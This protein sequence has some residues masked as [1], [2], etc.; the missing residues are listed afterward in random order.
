MIIVNLKGG[1]GNQTFQYALA[2]VLARRNE[3]QVAC[4]QRFLDERNR[5]RPRG[6][7]P[8]DVGLGDFGIS[9]ESPDRL[10]LIRTLMF[11]PSYAA[12]AA[13]ASVLD[14]LGSCTL[15]ERRRTFEPRVIKHREPTLY[16]D[17][18]WQSEHY[19]DGRHDDI[20]RLFA[21]GGKALHWARE[22][23]VITPEIV[24]DAACV[25]VRRGDFVG[26]RE[27]DC[28]PSNY[29]TQAFQRLQDRV[30]R[31][32]RPYVFSDDHRWCQRHIELPNEPIF[33]ACSPEATNPA[34]TLACMR[35]FRYFVIPNSTFGWW[36]AWLAA[37]EGK[38]VV[39]PRRWSG[40]L[41]V[42]KVDIVPPDW[43]TA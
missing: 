24:G 2:Y 21:T 22:L 5:R 28:L 27:H 41:A 17:G 40:T 42:D 36:G 14:R 8:R 16:L 31:P 13:I 1:L 6:Y 9:V 12:R 11:P 7:M 43:L 20:R 29:T 37:P 26:S 25:H 10:S 4:D 39:A 33:V 3:S 15:V 30:G 38:V 23:P 18:Y 35:Q 19:F 32:L 34:A